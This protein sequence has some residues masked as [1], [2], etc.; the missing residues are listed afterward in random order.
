M[1]PT[2]QQSRAK[3][4]HSVDKIPVQCTDRDPTSDISSHY[5]QPL[6]RFENDGHNSARS[7]VNNPSQP[8]TRG[9]DNTSYTGNSHGN[10]RV[11]Y[12]NADRSYRVVPEFDDN[13]TGV[14]VF[15]E[16][17]DGNNH[18][19]LENA[20]GNNRIFP[21]NADR[22][23]RIFPGNADRNNHIFLVNDDVE[24]VIYPGV[25]EELPRPNLLEPFPDPDLPGIEPGFVNIHN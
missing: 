3:K 17:A 25:N 8:A 11:L 23:N 20:D 19:F 10:Q 18:I 5:D 16:N 7:E 15:P 4:A 14:P 2:Q 1:E 22:N 13:N 24:Q 9:D 12:G 6:N 21:G